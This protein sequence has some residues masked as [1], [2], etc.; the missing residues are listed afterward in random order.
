M[1]IPVTHL[2]LLQPGRI[3]L[4]LALQV[5]CHIHMPAV[6][7]LRFERYVCQ[8]GLKFY[9]LGFGAFELVLAT[10]QPLAKLPRLVPRCFCF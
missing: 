4:Q 9:K 5:S 3:P 2:S 1:T 6:G 8:V 10:E 7:N